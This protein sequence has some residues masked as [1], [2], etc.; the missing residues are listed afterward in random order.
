ME[1][2]EKMAEEENRISYHIP[3]HT[4]IINLSTCLPHIRDFHVAGF[5]GT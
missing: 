2:K 3:C 1:K 4:P 5:R